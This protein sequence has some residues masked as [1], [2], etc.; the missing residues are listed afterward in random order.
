MTRLRYLIFILLCVL[1]IHARSQ[2][3]FKAI[4]KWA[5]QAPADLATDLPSLTPYLTQKAANETEKLRAIFAWVV[6][7]IVY[8]R[9]AALR[10]HPTNRSI[11][12]ILRDQKAICLGYAQLIARMCEL[13]G[14]EAEVISGYSKDLPT[15]K[16]MLEEPDHAWN[17]VKVDGKWQLLDATW[18]AAWYNYKYKQGLNPEVEPYFLAPPRQFIHAHL[19]AQPWWQL[20]DPPISVALFQAGA[21]SIRLHFSTAPS[22]YFFGDTIATFRALPPAR[23]RVREF[24]AAWQFQPSAAN[25]QQ[26]VNAL[27]EVAG[28]WTDSLAAFETPALLDTLIPQQ[29]R[30]LAW[31][32]YAGSL[33]SL[34]PWHQELYAEVLINHTVALYQKT[35]GS[36]SPSQRKEMMGLLE[37]AETVLIHTP[38]SYYTKMALRRCREY[39]GVLK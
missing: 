17:A 19:P 3:D 18:A 12:E 10:E 9:A 15:S 29:K 25:R 2:P 31:C 16:P 22:G 21:D 14:L 23:K 38:E 34:L 37:E 20:L 1:Q 33:G 5:R 11:G 32:R 7:H 39:K 4:D 28:A 35:G 36:P 26:Y 24:E 8:D 27:M 13:A 6:T 30:L